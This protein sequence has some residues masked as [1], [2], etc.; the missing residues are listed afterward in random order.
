MATGKPDKTN[1]ERLNVFLKAELNASPKVT[2][3]ADLS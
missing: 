3:D 2:A 1:E